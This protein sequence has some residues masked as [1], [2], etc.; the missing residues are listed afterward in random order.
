MRS[1]SRDAGGYTTLP[2]ASPEQ[3]PISH[4]KRWK[5]TVSCSE[6]ASPVHTPTRKGRGPS[7]A[8]G[9]VH[10]ETI[11]QLT[12]DVAISVR[13]LAGIGHLSHVRVGVSRRYR[14]KS[15]ASNSH[16]TNAMRLRGRLTSGGTHD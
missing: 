12:T 15:Y 7:G 3:P 13:I 10:A 2:C 14:K 6:P 11:I 8:T 1:R 16:D 4:S 5:V 9:S